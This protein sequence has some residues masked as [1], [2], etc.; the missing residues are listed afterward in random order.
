MLSLGY[1]LLNYWC[2]GSFLMFSMALLRQ[3]LDLY[4]LGYWLRRLVCLGFQWLLHS[5]LRFKHYL[6]LLKGWGLS[7]SLSLG[8]L[9][10]LNLAG[11]FGFFCTGFNGRWISL[12]SP[13]TKSRIG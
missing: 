9:R 2:A 6:W 3:I 1:L 8:L 12:S 4:G 10:L 13:Y 7:L 5:L 11:C